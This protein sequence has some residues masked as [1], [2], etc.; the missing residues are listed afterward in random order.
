LG[1]AARVR[2]RKKIEEIA[3]ALASAGYTSLDA[4]ARVLGLSRSTAWTVLTGVHKSSGLSASTVN[5]ILSTGKL[6]R[7]VQR[8]LVEY[9]ADKVSGIYGDR[10]HRLKAFKEKIDSVYLEAALKEISRR[11]S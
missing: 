5:K 11:D 9:L 1:N 8:K 4:Q 10:P 3:E 7:E 6:P 2:Q